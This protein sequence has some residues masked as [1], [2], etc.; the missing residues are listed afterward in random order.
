MTLTPADVDE[1]RLCDAGG[2]IVGRVTAFYHYP[3]ELDAPWGVVAVTTGSIF[4]TTRLVDLYDATLAA[5]MVISA[6]PLQQIKTAPNYRAAIGGVL[7]DDHA[8]HVL[9]HYRGAPQL[10]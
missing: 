6:Y 9:S 1:R 10:D 4:R 8:A 3:A 5:D 2:R 7:R